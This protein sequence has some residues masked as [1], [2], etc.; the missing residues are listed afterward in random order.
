MT[1]LDSCAGSCTTAIAAIETG[2]NYICM[3]KDKEIFEVGNNRVMQYLE[4]T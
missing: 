3:E 4:E 1:I 2:R